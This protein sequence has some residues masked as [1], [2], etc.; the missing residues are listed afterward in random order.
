MKK[1]TLQK[2]FI[3]CVLVAMLLSGCIQAQPQSDKGEV[4]ACVIGDFSGALSTYGNSTKQGAEIAVAEIND[5]G[6]INGAEIFLKAFDEKTDPVEA[7]KVAQIAIDECVA[8]I[9]GS[10]SGPALAMAPLFEEAGVPFIATVSSNKTL[11]ESEYR[12]VSRVQLSDYDQ[13]VRLTSY[14]AKNT[15]YKK[16][17]LLHDTTDFG[18]GGK[19]Y[20]EEVIG[21]RDDMEVVAY[22]GWRIEDVDYSSQI[23]NAKNAGADSIYIIGAAE[24]SARIVQQVSQLGVDLQIFGTN[25]MGNQKFLDLAGESAEG[26]IFPYGAV[27]PNNEIVI[28]LQKKMEE[29]Y[30]RSADVFVSHAYDAMYVLADSMKKAGTSNTDRP[31]IQDAIRSGKYNYSLGDLSFDSTGN[32]IRHI[33]IAEVKDGAF[34]IIE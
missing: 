11:T 13:V 22:E 7:V 26:L 25:T 24:G 6:G 29:S 2:T 14:I 23:L 10:G 20:V 15:N 33:F 16:I 3:I 8:V 17:A 21:T 19:E 5:S 30:S 18:L 12:Y 1:W 27:D 9:I 34:V 31:A 32:N 4:V 28:K